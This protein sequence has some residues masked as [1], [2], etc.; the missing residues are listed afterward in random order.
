MREIVIDTDTRI[1][2]IYEDKSYY[3]ENKNTT[4]LRT[5][6]TEAKKVLDIVAPDNEVTVEDLIALATNPEYLTSLSFTYSDD[7]AYIATVQLNEFSKHPITLNAEKSK[8]YIMNTDYI[9]DLALK[10]GRRNRLVR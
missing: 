4:T 6:A 9:F 10:E 7:G 1:Y 2:Y 8:L 3:I 5:D